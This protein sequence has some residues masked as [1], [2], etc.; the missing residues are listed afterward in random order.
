MYGAYYY[1]MGQTESKPAKRRPGGPGNLIPPKG[2]AESYQR[3]Q[4]ADLQNGAGGCRTPEVQFK[5]PAKFQSTDYKMKE[6]SSAIDFQVHHLLR[7]RCTYIIIALQYKH[8]GY[9]CF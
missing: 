8:F 9:I 4:M 2:T 6:Q 3:G 1:M 5:D 7:R